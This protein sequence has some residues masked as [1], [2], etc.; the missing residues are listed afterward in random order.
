MVLW[1][2]NRRKW[3]ATRCGAKREDEF[4][5]ECYRQQWV[6]GTFQDSCLTPCETDPEGRERLRSILKGAGCF[7]HGAS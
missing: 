2:F 1:S 4:L 7:A 3:E 5:V 6:S